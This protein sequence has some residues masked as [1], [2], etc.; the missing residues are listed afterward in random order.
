MYSSASCEL[1]GASLPLLLLSVH[2]WQ[3]VGEAV[4]GVL[5]GRL[6]EARR[7]EHGV[8]AV[9]VLAADVAEP[10]ADF[11]RCVRVAVRMTEDV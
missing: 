8:A 1:F 11:L 5:G 2:R 10:R 9:A 3:D 7:S 4:H 6:V